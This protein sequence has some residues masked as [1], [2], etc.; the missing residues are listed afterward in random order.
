MFVAIAF[1]LEYRAFVVHTVALSVNF[2][3]MIHPSKKVQIVYLK[4]DEVRT[5][6]P[7]KYAD[8]V[9][10]FLL[11]LIIKFLKHIKAKNYG[12]KFMDDW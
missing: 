6:I 5:K 8:F 11:K 4:A 2:N 10:N 3:D 7:S 9:D 1:N 12:I